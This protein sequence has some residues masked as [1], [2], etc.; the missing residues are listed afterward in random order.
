MEARR[1]ILFA[2]DRHYNQHSGKALYDVIGN[3]YAMD[4]YEDDWRCFEDPALAE[5][6]DLMILNLI[7]G[8]CDVDAPTPAQVSNVRSYLE[9]GKPLLLLHG[10]S[11][12]FW[13]HA[14]WREIVGYRWV[15][16]HDPDGFESSYHP[17]EPY[18]IRVSKTRH[19]LCKA[20]QNIDFPKDE[21]YLALEQTCPT[22]TLMETKV[23]QGTFPMCYETISP[24][25]GK[26]VGY[27]PGHL[28]E[29]VQ[30]P[31]NVAN[32]RVLID[33]LLGKS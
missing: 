33:Y 23:E 16:P 15:R 6:Y 18:S 21:I 32:S 13:D 9:V 2:A 11:A 29:V 4:F 5:K 19:P 22:I 20:L 31:E 3:D 24:W 10:A 17:K 27:L 1:M 8:T 26:I 25:G 30:L 28:P 14:W 7:G 12:A